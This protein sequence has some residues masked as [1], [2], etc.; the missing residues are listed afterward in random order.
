VLQE[1]CECPIS[2]EIFSAG[3]RVCYIEYYDRLA[4]SRNKLSFELKESL[5]VFM[6]PVLMLRQ[7]VTMY[8]LRDKNPKELRRPNTGGTK[9]W[10]ITSEQHDSIEHA[11]E[12]VFKDQDE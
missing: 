9:H 2:G 10:G 1:D 12:H 4:G 11:I 3:E 8:D 6:V 7:V 5:G